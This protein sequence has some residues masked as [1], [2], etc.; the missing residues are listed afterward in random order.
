ML[1]IDNYVVLFSLVRFLTQCWVFNVI[2]IIY[3]QVAQ[4][5][6]FLDHTV[7]G[8]KDEIIVDLI[9]QCRSYQKR[10]MVLVNNTG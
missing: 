1:S 9:D 2:T 8:L 10:V 4:T 6:N 3:L 7:Q 5:I